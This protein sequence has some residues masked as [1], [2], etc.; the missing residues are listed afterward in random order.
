MPWSNTI[1]DDRFLARHLVREPDEERDR[2]RQVAKSLASDADS[3]LELKIYRAAFNY[4]SHLGMAASAPRT[5]VVVKELEAVAVTCK[6]AANA[7]DKLNDTAL[8]EWHSCVDARVR[9]GAAG[10][11]LQ[12]LYERAIGSGFPAH[13]EFCY[14]NLDDPEDCRGWNYGPGGHL[15][16]IVPR[17]RN[18]AE[19]AK[20]LIECIKSRDGDDKGGGRNVYQKKHG[21]PVWHLAVDCWEI[22]LW[23][24]GVPT[25]AENGEFN[26]FVQA[27]HEYATEQNEPPKGLRDHVRAVVKLMNESRRLQAKMPKHFNDRPATITDAE[28]R[29]YE[30]LQDALATGRVP[31]WLSS[32]K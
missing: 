28:I 7:I 24:A 11:K 18:T 13:V 27:V 29:Q 3:R 32:H 30:E 17:L 5:S 12:Q 1:K 4:K 14:P 23:H 15:V 22:F 26:G 10:D 19:L 16:F 31:T 9:F 2:I 20:Q 6:A 8:E 21:S 25:G